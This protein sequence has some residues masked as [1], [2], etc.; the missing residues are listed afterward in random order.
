MYGW[1]SKAFNPPI[2]HKL[3]TVNT[4]GEF[5][6]DE[7]SPDATA[8]YY[9]SVK[10]A[11]AYNGF[12]NVKTAF[13]A[14]SNGMPDIIRTAKTKMESLREL[15]VLVRK[16]EKVEEYVSN[17]LRVEMTL[18]TNIVPGMNCFNQ[19]ADIRFHSFLPHLETYYVPWD[20]YVEGMVDAFSM[21]DAFRCFRL[22]DHTSLKDDLQDHTRRAFAFVMSS[23]ALGDW[24]VAHALR[25]WDWAHTRY[26]YGEDQGGAAA[27]RDYRARL[28]RLYEDYR[29]HGAPHPCETKGPYG[30]GW[31][32]CDESPEL[33]PGEGFNVPRPRTRSM[34]E[35]PGEPEAM[36]DEDLP[37]PTHVDIGDVEYIARNLRVRPKRTGMGWKYYAVAPGRGCWKGR[38]FATREELF[39]NVS[40]LYGADWPRHFRA[41]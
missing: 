21:V 14:V 39:E 6:P 15:S 26:N 29:Y 28:R 34:G 23:M 8:G 38:G 1:V 9:M 20:M 40:Q 5:R 4:T 10:K 16:D 3:T 17:K 37:N 22:D 12:P 19:M 33:D 30:D 13:T 7:D 27:F 25:G 32:E 18:L 11:V 31:Q 41:I 35:A 36:A 24:S 2:P